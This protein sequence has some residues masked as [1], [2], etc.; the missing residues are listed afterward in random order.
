[1]AQE[2]N[3]AM[4]IRELPVTG[5]DVELGNA[6]TVAGRAGL[7]ITFLERDPLKRDLDGEFVIFQAPFIQQKSKRRKIKDWMQT[8]EQ[9]LISEAIEHAACLTQDLEFFESYKEKEKVAYKDFDGW[10]VQW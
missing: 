6:S 8:F 3:E 1:V 9:Q 10:L 2:A 5:S 7:D 4:D